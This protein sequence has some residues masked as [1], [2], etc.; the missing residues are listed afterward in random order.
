MGLRIRDMSLDDIDKVY[1]INKKSFTTD[2]WSRDAIEREFR[3]NYSRRYVLEEN[4]N[5]LGYAVLWVIK[6][7]AF[8]MTFAI[9]PA[10]RNRGLGRKFLEKIISKLKGEAQVLQLDVRKSNLPA[11]RLYRSLGFRV[12]KERP[13]FYSDGESALLMELM[14]GRIEGD[15]GDKGKEALTSDKGG[16]HK[17]EGKGV[18]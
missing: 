17:E 9:D 13:K 2:A 10:F 12:V 4:G 18:R 3:L 14:L 15:E 7:E 8:L 5:I 16:R 6:G 11:I 1:E